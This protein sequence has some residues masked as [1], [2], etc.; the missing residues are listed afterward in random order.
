MA[1]NHLGTNEDLANYPGRQQLARPSALK[2]S[3]MGLT[4][5]IDRTRATVSVLQWFL[6]LR[7]TLECARGPLVAFDA[8]EFRES[9]LRF[10]RQHFEA[11]KKTRIGPGD[12]APVLVSKED[13]RF[14]KNQRAIRIAEYPLGQLILTPLEFRKFSLNGLAPLPVEL[15]RSVA[16]DAKPSEFWNVFDEVLAATE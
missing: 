3:R 15:E 6:N 14:L 16:L 9:G 2:G 10:I 12:T 7:E 13:K 4:V 1:A 5:F 8:K 11:Y